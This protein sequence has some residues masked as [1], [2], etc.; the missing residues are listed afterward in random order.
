MNPP[1]GPWV[2]QAVATVD[3]LV[4]PRSKQDR[5]A[6]DPNGAVQVAVTS[7]PHDG[8]ANRH[9]VKLLAKRLGVPQ[10]AIAIV[11][12]AGSRH[13]VLAVDMLDNEQ[14]QTRLRKAHGPKK[15]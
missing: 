5:I 12:G 15:G 11:R 8:K 1:I 7:P 9:V 10:S 4:K 3:V 13:K 2:V 14:I 6:V